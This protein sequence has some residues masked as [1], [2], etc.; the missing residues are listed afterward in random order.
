MTRVLIHDQCADGL[1]SFLQCCT[2][3][4]LYLNVDN[5]DRMRDC[6]RS[7]VIKACQSGSSWSRCFHIYDRRLELGLVVCIIE[8]Y[9]G[10]EPTS[11]PASQ[12]TNQPASQ[13]LDHT[14]HITMLNEI[15]KSRSLIP[16]S[17]GPAQAWPY[18]QDDYSIIEH[19]TCRRR[20]AG[21]IRGFAL[22][23]GGKG[24]EGIDRVK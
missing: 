7:S 8:S 11:Q 10:I 15:L 14:S 6:H 1:F 23:L 18:T 12:P 16:D 5:I 2:L 3:P 4:L 13:K 20:D 19:S 17:R 22:T 21:T 9:G 24:R